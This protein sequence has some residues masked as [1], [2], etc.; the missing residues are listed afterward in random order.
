MAKGSIRV[1]IVKEGIKLNKLDRILKKHASPTHLRTAI[2]RTNKKILKPVA[3]ALRI[4][5]QKQNMHPK[6]GSRSKGLARMIR[7][8]AS[9]KDKYGTG[10]I[11]MVPQGQFLQ[12]GTKLRKNRGRIASNAWASKIYDRWEP[13]VRRRMK[14][15]YI[16]L[17]TKSIKSNIE[18]TRG[19]QR[20]V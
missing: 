7:V 5:A 3:N 15:D 11:V 16:K 10:V 18:L 4:A 8:L 1:S 14:T 12:S 9:K 19:R 6:R 17:F 20:V 2:Q 13:R